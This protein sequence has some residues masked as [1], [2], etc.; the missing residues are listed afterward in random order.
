MPTTAQQT[1]RELRQ[2]IKALSAQIEKQAR[3]AAGHANGSLRITRDDIR[4]LAENAGET[5]RQYFI[6]K[7]DQAQEVVHDAATKYEDSVAAHPWKA[8]GLAMLG[9]AVLTALLFRR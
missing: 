5:A 4:E 2:E 6:V 7:R 9:G 3:N 8:T 1:I